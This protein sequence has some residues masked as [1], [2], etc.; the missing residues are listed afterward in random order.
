MPRTDRNAADAFEI[1]EARLRSMARHATDIIVLL[2]ESGGV[3]EACPR[4]ASALGHDPADLVGHNLLGR[5]HPDDR[6]KFVAAISATAAGNQVD[7]MVAVRMK[8]ADGGWHDLETSL[9]TLPDDPAAEGILVVARDITERKRDEDRVHV[10]EENHRHQAL[11]DHLTGLPNRALFMDRVGQALARTLRHD[12][13]P[14]VAVFLFELDQFKLVVD[15]FG[16]GIGDQLLVEAG[17]V[18]GRAVRPADTVARLSDDAFAVCCENLRDEGEVLA[19]AAR[20]A[21]HLRER[22]VAHDHEFRVTASIGIALG[23]GETGVTPESLIRDADVAVSR[24]KERGGDRH[25]VFD[26]TARL[27]ALERLQLENG[28]RAALRHGD[29]R[30]Y[31]QPTIR[32]DDGCVVGAEALVRWQHATRGLLMP[33]HFIPVAEDTGLVVPLGVAVIEDAC[34]QVQAWRSTPGRRDW[35]VAVNVSGRQLSDGALLDVVQRAL[36][37]W[38]VPPEALCLELTESA[39]MADPDQAASTL[40][41]LHELGVKLAI[42]DFGTGYSSLTY[43]RRFPIDALKVDRSFVNG[44]SENIKDATI[45]AAVVAL[46]HAFGIPAIAEGVET[47]AQAA[48]LT[49]MGCEFA[50][51]YLWGK[52]LPAALFTVPD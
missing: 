31:Y 33:G 12:P 25:E 48:Q 21:D 26:E 20:L 40:W 49:D 51:G 44:V 13:R 18:L 30:F 42:D 47:D 24:A 4:A 36:E 10:L 17:R 39:L 11:H 8:A 22:M 9:T 43:L 32:L 2:D 37:T 1:K 15:S 16:H 6:Q 34:R 52:P 7:E 50:Q 35:T 23:R 27:R 5:V 41:A 29:L 45:V 46:A 19:T 14:L 28:L 38:G 3:L